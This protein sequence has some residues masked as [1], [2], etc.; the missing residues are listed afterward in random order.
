MR[1]LAT[2]LILAMVASAPMAQVSVGTDISPFGCQMV[3]PNDGNLT[4]FLDRAQEAGVDTVRCDAMWWGLVEYPNPGEYHWDGSLY[5]GYSA[6]NVDSW[7]SQVTSRGMEPFAGIALAFF[8]VWNLI[9]ANRRATHYNRAVDGLGGEAPPE[10]FK[11][12][13]TGGSIFGGLVLIFIGLLFFLDL[14]FGISMAWVWDWWPLALVGG[15]V[16]LVVSAMNKKK[17]AEG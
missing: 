11:I 6:W 17:N 15:G 2:T 1:S 9:D 7:I 3:W 16:Y 10:D 13:G 12:P 14:K 4:T 5:P 8:W